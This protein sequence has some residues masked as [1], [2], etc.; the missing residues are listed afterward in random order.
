M[1]TLGCESAI[2]PDRDD[3][4]RFFLQ[5][6]VMRTMA[7]HGVS[8]MATVYEALIS[9]P[10]GSRNLPSAGS[11]TIYLADGA[12]ASPISRTGIWIMGVNI[13]LNFIWIPRYA[14][15]G[16]AWATLTSYTVAWT[17]RP[18]GIHSHSRYGMGR[19]AE[20]DTRGVGVWRGS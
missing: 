7:Y 2:K 1:K 20:G 4:V 6:E 8:A 16:S 19:I 17:N 5:G 14:A 12:E 15:V 10:G 11:G 3:G 9:L 13:L 18:F